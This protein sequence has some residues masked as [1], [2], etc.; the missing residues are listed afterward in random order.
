MNGTLLQVKVLFINVVIFNKLFPQNVIL[1]IIYHNGDPNHNKMYHKKKQIVPQAK[2]WHF[3]FT[4]LTY[5]WKMKV[6][7]INWIGF[8]LIAIIWTENWL[9]SNVRQIWPCQPI[10]EVR[11]D[12]NTRWTYNCSSVRLSNHSFIIND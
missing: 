1:N 7:N 10:F 2:R 8:L 11:D 3:F 6:Q 4:F 5:L 9:P 12:C